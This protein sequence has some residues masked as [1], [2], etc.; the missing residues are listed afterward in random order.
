[1]YAYNFWLENKNIMNYYYY[2]FVKI[3]IIFFISGN[4]SRSKQMHINFSSAAELLT[5]FS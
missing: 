3:I 2:F 4:L 5:C 1:M